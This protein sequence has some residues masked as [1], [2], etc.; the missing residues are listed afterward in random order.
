M[1]KRCERHIPRELSKWLINI[2]RHAQLHSPSRKWKWKPKWDTT[3]HPVLDKGD[4][5]E[6]NPKCWWRGGE[7]TTHKSMVE[8]KLIQPLW[9]SE[10]YEQST[11]VHPMTRNSTPGI[12]PEEMCI[13]F[14]QEIH[15]RMLK[16]VL[17]TMVKTWRQHKCLSV[18][19]WINDGTIIP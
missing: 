3:T 13:H 15:A 12:H 14:Y 16:A 6:C 2:G 1:G 4:N 19:E 18:V 10:W 5:K 9:K 7:N 8:C 11:Y 17:F